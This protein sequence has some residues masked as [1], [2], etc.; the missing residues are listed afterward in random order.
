MELTRPN[1]KMKSVWILTGSLG[2]IL[3]SLLLFLTMLLSSTY[4]DLPVET[5]WI[6]LAWIIF[7]VVW[8]ILVATISI[9]YY[10]S[11]GYRLTEDFLEINF[12][13]LWLKT[14]RVP[15]ARIQNVNV[16]RGPFM[17]MFGLCKVVAETAGKSASSTQW[18]P[19][20]GT[21]E[22]WIP[23]P[24]EGE[25]VVEDILN[26]VKEHHGGALSSGV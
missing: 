11:W 13:I 22:A 17:R 26:R 8:I 10:N 23:G 4:G 3:L 20:A 19:R 21:P 16:I 18:G 2:G 1:S 12:G 5:F 25:A 6:F 7:L 24:A 15:Y 14:N 9:L